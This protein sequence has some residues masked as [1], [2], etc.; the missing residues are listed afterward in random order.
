MCDHFCKDMQPWKHSVP[1]CHSHR[2]CI[3]DAADYGLTTGDK[4]TCKHFFFFKNGSFISDQAECYT[5]ELNLCL[6]REKKKQGLSK[7][8][9]WGGGRGGSQEFDSQIAKTD[10]FNFPLSVHFLKLFGGQWV[11]WIKS[12]EKNKRHY[13]WKISLSCSKCKK[14]FSTCKLTMGQTAV[15]LAGPA[16]FKCFTPKVPFCLSLL[17]SNT[18]LGAKF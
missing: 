6:F 8:E 3:W 18:F 11:N 7:Q 16:H 13:K 14:I 10:C 5:V 15:S 4:T 1:C 12:T 2:V 9:S 17:L